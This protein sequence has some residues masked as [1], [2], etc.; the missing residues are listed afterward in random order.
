MQAEIRANIFKKQT[1][2]YI[3]GIIF[4]CGW[5]VLSP[6]PTGSGVGGV[7]PTFLIMYENKGGVNPLTFCQK[8]IGTRGGNPS[9]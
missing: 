2:A 9:K 4:L 8:C 1:F 6:T 3:F 7:D 5:V